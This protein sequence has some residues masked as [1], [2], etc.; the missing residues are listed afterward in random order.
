MT[1]AAGA[2]PGDPVPL[3]AGQLSLTGR[4]C[5]VGTQSI[6]V[7]LKSEADRHAAALINGWYDNETGEHD[8]E[9]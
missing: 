8:D 3:L 1:R 2:W 7:F 5:H 4:P 6:G 9:A